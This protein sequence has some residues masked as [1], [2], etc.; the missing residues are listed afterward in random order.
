MR[1]IEIKFISVVSG[2][3]AAPAW[4]RRCLLTLLVC[5]CYDRADAV[6]AGVMTSPR[7]QES[8]AAETPANADA[9]PEVSS[10]P[11]SSQPQGPVTA[12]VG[13]RVM[14]AA[15]AG[16]LESGVILVAD[17]K[18][19]AIGTDVAVPS[20]ARVVDWSGKVVTPG[21]VDPY[22]VDNSLRPGTTSDADSAP[23]RFGGRVFPG[24]GRGQQTESTEFLSVRDLWNPQPRSTAVAMRSGTTTLHWVT[25]GFGLSL[26]SA[27]T[28]ETPLAEA[29]WGGRLFVAASNNT[30]TLDVIRNGL[31]GRPRGA[32]GGGPSPGQRAGGGRGR[33][34]RGE[35][36]DSGV[37]VDTLRSADPAFQESGRQGP[38]SG[39]GRSGGANSP[40]EPEWEAIRKGERPLVINA[41]SPAAILHVL[42]IKATAP[43]AK[44]V[45]VVVSSDAYQVLDR[46]EG[47]GIG[48]IVRPRLELVPNSAVRLNLPAELNRRSIPFAF[49]LSS[50]TSEF[51]ASQDTP[52]FPVSTLVRTG[53]P[54]ERALV[55]LTLEPAKLL[56][57]DQQVGSLEVGKSADMLVFDRDPLVQVGR[58]EQVLVKGNL[59]YENQ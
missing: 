20:S 51:V 15:Q 41:N 39:S 31:A 12:Y 40:T 7:T 57:I 22:Y 6:I 54:A 38:P 28:N 33:R 25:S 44:L 53:L 37:Q 52:L 43:Q 55:A 21:I 50:N 59:V 56:G 42:S 45:L 30:A 4:L 29:E 16:T 14:T 11:V 46:L 47:S 58:L 1:T 3:C 8:S 2:G 10:A 13:A 27:M 35:A 24:A 48:L 5:C 32:G 17:G 23:I 9:K 26:F 49:T 19:L 18:I 36:L 34:P